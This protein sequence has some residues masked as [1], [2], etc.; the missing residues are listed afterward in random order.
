MGQLVAGGGS[1]TLTLTQGPAE[2]IT[3]YSG[4]SALAGT[5]R[6]LATTSTTAN[7]KAGQTLLTPC[8]GTTGPAQRPRC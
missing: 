4:D 3:E 5:L 2:V 6:L 8:M 7:A 1:G